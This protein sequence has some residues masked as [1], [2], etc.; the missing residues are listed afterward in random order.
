MKGGVAVEAASKI[1]C[2]VFDKT[3]TLT[4][5]KLRVEAASFHLGTTGGWTGGSEKADN[6]LTKKL[7]SAALA[8]AEKSGHPA[9]VAVAAWLREQGAPTLWL[10]TGQH[11]SATVFYER[12]GWRRVGVSSNG[13]ARY[14]LAD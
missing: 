7:A 6:A 13:E 8:L 2:V 3:G 12:L 11:T 10:M 9:S 14:E 4:A 5:G 1:T